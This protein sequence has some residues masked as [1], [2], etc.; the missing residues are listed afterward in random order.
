MIEEFEALALDFKKLSRAAC[1][2]HCNGAS[3]ACYQYKDEIVENNCRIVLPH[4]YVQTRKSKTGFH[5]YVREGAVPAAAL[6]TTR[7]QP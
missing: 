5:A 7:L 1:E 4:E 6:A 3:C 2:A